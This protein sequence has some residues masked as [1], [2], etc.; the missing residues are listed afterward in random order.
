MLAARNDTAS[1]KRADRRQAEKYD[2]SVGADVSRIEVAL[3]EKDFILLEDV[4]I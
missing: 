1:K 3:S 4:Q 2:F